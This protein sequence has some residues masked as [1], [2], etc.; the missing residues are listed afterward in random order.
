ME[1]GACMA[2]LK[3]LWIKIGWPYFEAAEFV[4]K[5]G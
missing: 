5:I 1:V 2:I 3:H 4:G